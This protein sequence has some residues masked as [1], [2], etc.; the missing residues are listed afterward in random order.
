MLHLPERSVRSV[1]HVQVRVEYQQ[2]EVVD[3][4]PYTPYEH[5]VA[6]FSLSSVHLTIPEDTSDLRNE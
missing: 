3:Q 1:R 4:R 5:S 6:I 2:T